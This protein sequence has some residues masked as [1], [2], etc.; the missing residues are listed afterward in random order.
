MTTAVR[1]PVTAY[2]EAVTSGAVV[3]GRLVSLAAERHI[4]DIEHG[5]ERGLH[6]DDDAAQHAI[7]FFRLLRLPDGAGAGQPFD[8]EPWECFIVGSLF[9]WMKG[10][11]R[12]FHYALV[13]VARS[14]GKSPLSGGIGAYGLLAD[15]ELG[16]QIYS[17]AT[18]RDQAKIVFND[19]V[20]MVEKTPALWKQLLKTVN[21]LANVKQGSYFRPLSADASTMDGLRVHIALV[22]EL[23][24]HPNGEVIAKLRTGM[25]SSQP[26]LF[27]ITTAGWDRSSVCWQE[28]EVVVKIL[29]GT[30]ENDAYFGYIATLDPEDDWL[31]EACWP[32]AN[33][34]LGVSV[35][36]ETL[37]DEARL[38][39]Q[40]PAQENDFKRLRLNTWTQQSSR[41]LTAELWEEGSIE[42]PEPLA[43]RQAYAG[44][45]ATNDMA[46][47]VLWVPDDAGGGDVLPFFFLPEEKAAELQAQENAPYVTWGDADVIEMTS[48]NVTDYD[49]LVKRLTELNE[50][51]DIREVAIHSYNRSNLETHLQDAGFTVAA[52][53]S[54]YTHMSAPTLEL[55]RLLI[56]RKL[57]H[58]GNPALRWMSGNIAVRSD[59]EGHKRPD[60]EA[61]GG[62]IGGIRALIMA[63]GR[64]MVYVDEDPGPSVYEERGFLTL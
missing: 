61:S 24:E 64:A 34:N 9:G 21:N 58:A 38:A 31:D 47:V 15:R 4:R 22:D 20:R 12:R 13:E 60:D 51:Y 10:D 27:M 48:G 14:N 52:V 62:R 35:R 25:K 23:H 59:S 7:D 46:A 50:T 6:F 53:T 3:T 11:K 30:L 49:L 44:V 36:M 16:A 42:P 45:H 19:G 18:T 33:P 32:K 37:R 26:L 56:A 40:I 54:G 43:R 28:H 1:S 8:L 55:E 17:A 2:A 29:E 41:W 57:R 63:I 5:H 39:Q